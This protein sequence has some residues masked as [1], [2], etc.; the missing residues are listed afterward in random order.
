[1]YQS[2]FARLRS[3]CG[4]EGQ[5]KEIHG[6]EIMARVLV[7]SLVA[8]TPRFPATAELR[9]GLDPLQLGPGSPFTWGKQMKQHV[10]S[11]TNT[12]TAGGICAV[13][14]LSI[15]SSR[16]PTSAT[17][18][19]Y[20]QPVSQPGPLFQRRRRMRGMMRPRVREC[21]GSGAVA[22]MCPGSGPRT[23]G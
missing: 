10:T 21:L 8:P 20:T 18:K 14:R 5:T 22:I 13:D 11:G 16:P 9:L 3:N 15:S 17:T 6:I 4:L 1:M 19:N 23:A 2:N 7:A 12:N